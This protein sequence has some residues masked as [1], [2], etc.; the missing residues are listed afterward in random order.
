MLLKHAHTVKIKKNL[1]ILI[2][3]LFP[4]VVALSTYL[5]FFYKQEGKIGAANVTDSFNDT[6]HIDIVNSSDYLV[7]SGQVKTAGNSSYFGTGADGACTVSASTNINTGTCVSRANGDAVNFS[8]TTNVSAGSGSI[9]LSSSPTGLAVGDEILIINLQGTTSSNIGV[10]ETAYISQINGNTLT[11]E[12]NL[13]NGFDGT[14]QKIMVQ[15]I[16][17]YTSVTVNSGY[18][19]YPSA[20]NGAKGG[21]LMFRATGTVTVNGTIHANASGYR[22]GTNTSWNG[23]L[24]GETYT[25]YGGGIGGSNT[26]I[27]GKNGSTSGG[28]G[29]AGVEGTGAGTIGTGGVGGSGGGGGFASGIYGYLTKSGGGGGGGYGTGGAKGSA[30]GYDDAVNGTTGSSGNG[31]RGQASESA[32]SYGGGGGGGGTYGISN[33]TK[34]F[35]GSGG[36]AGGAAMAFTGGAGGVGGGIVVVA[37]KTVTVNSGG[38]IRSNGG[39]GGNSQV[40]GEWECAADRSPAGGGAGAG[41]S[42]FL[43]TDSASI[44]TSH[45][46]GPGGTGGLGNCNNGGAGGSGRIRIEYMT[47]L[48][49]TSSPASSTAQLPVYAP[50]MIL[51]STDLITEIYDVQIK[52]FVYNLSSKPSGT[53]ATVQFSKDGTNWYSSGGVLGASD[54]LAIGTDNS[55]DLSGLNWETQNFFY[56]VSFGTNG[57]TATPV[58]NDVTLGYDATPQAPT[59]GDPETLS[60]TSIRWKFTDNATNETGFK[61][62][63]AS[64]VLVKT[65]NTQNL[66]YI[67]ETNLSKNTQYTRKVAAFNALG[68]SDLTI[69][70]S[71]YTLADVPTISLGG[72]SAT[73]AGL[74]AGNTANLA[75]GSSGLFFD[76]IGEGCDEGINQWVQTNTD[77]ATGL[78]A[79]T[80]YTFKVRAR[81]GN[82]VETLNSSNIL[83][84]TL[85]NVP[86]LSI[87]N[88]TTSG[89][90]LTAGNTANLTAG[91]SGLYFDCTGTG[92]DEGIN[93]WTQSGSDIVSGLSENTQYTFQVKARNGD[94]VETAYSGSSNKYT[95]LDTPSILSSSVGTNQIEITAD[96][97][98]NKG[99]GST[100]LYFDCL[101]ENCDTGLNEWV[102]SSTGISTGLENNSVYEYRVMG[103]NAEGIETAYSDTATFYTLPAVPVLSVDSVNTT[104]ISLSASGINNLTEGSSGLYFDCTGIN[105]DEGINQ[106]IQNT[107]DIATNLSVNTQ[108]TFVSKGRSRTGIETANSNMVSA[109]TRANIPGVP[110]FV[111]KETN[112]VTIKISINGNPSNTQYLIQEINTGQYLN[113]STKLLTTTPSW[114]S[115]ASLGGTNGIEISGLNAG[116]IYVF[117]VKARNG[118]NIETE[119]GNTL[120]VTTS[121]FSPTMTAPEALS[122]TSIKWKFTDNDATETGF[123][124]VDT[125]NIDRVTCTGSNLSFCAETGLTPGTGY[126]RR[127]YA[128]NAT[129]QSLYSNLVSGYTFSNIPGLPVGRSTDSVSANIQINTNGNGSS[130]QYSI[131]ESQSGRFVDISSGNLSTT[132]A[133]A[134]Y[135]SWGGSLGMDVL[136]LNANESYQFRI[137]AKNGAGSV[138]EYSDASTV[139]TRANVPVNV[140]N[141]DI[142]STSIKVSFGTNRNP[143]WTEYAVQDENSGRFVNPVT[144][145]LVS[146]EVWG[147]YSIFGGIEG[148]TV[149]SLDVNKEY[150]F[151][152]KARNTEGVETAY[153]DPFSIMTLFFSPT[154]TAP[155]ALSTTSIKWKF[156]DNDATETGF[157][158]VDTSNIDRVTC[159]GSNLSFC[160]ETGLTPGTGYSRRV[161][162]YN[163]TSQSLYSNL[164]SGY[165]FSNIPGLPVGR[166]TDSV[167]ANIQIN[168]NGNGSSTQ[169]SI[170]ESQSGRF[171]DI[172]SGN[173]STTEAWAS[174]VS[175]GGSLGMDVLGLNANESYQFRIR[176][177]NGAGSVTEYSDA[178]TVVTR[179]NIPAN[180]EN[181][182]ISF[183]S[184][185]V[186]FGTNGNPSQTEYAIQDE[187]SGNFINPITRNLVS[188][189]VWGAYTIYGSEDGLT[190][191]GLNPEEEYNFRVKARNS[192]GVETAY[193]T[194]SGDTILGARILNIPS[195]L[196]A[197]LRSNEKILVTTEDGRQ[198]G[199]KNVRIKAEDYLIA[200]IPV[201]FTIDRDWIN[202]ILEINAV[203]YKSVIKLSEKE[204]LD[205]RFIMYVISGDT[206]AF[207]LCPEAK[208]LDDIRSGCKGEVL[209]EGNFPQEKE[210]EGSLVTVSKAKLNDIMYW[211]VDGLNGTGGEGYVAEEDKQE[212]TTIEKAVLG[213]LGTTLKEIV[214][215]ARGIIEDSTIGKLDEGELQTVATTTSVITVT[216]GA[217]LAT[218]GIPQLFYVISQALNGILNWLGFKRKKVH[219]GFVYDSY[220]KEPLSGVVV[221]IYDTKKNLVETFVTNENGAFEGNLEPGIYSIEV[222]SRG[223]FFPS[224]LVKGKV[225]LPIKNVYHGGEFILSEN[226]IVD[227]AIPV[228]SE[229]LDTKKKGETIV[230]SIFGNL[231]AILNVFLFVGGVGITLYMYG[232]YPSSTNLLLLLVYIPALYALISSF[233]NG[234]KKYGVVKDISGKP[235]EGI[236]VGIKE[237]EFG[238]LVS[239]R[240]TNS[241]GKYRII[242]PKGKYNIEIL[243]KDY[244]VENMKGGSEVNAK[245]EIVINKKIVVKHK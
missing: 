71:I 76:C 192:E 226:E 185:K 149:G 31:G 213:N 241:K 168:T 154:M 166:S 138:T 216:V 164:V 2:I 59:I 115:Y 238:Q 116:Q 135:V 147:T 95:L 141:T 140:E 210:V 112:S 232:K 151:R 125:S 205:G 4:I 13:T 161:Y 234:W 208:S 27:N 93:S 69:S 108:Y 228:D 169:Y 150:N 62:F 77:T 28:G 223:Y 92:C 222:K 100:A 23:G 65:V 5:I 170:Q 74:T 40:Y 195:G 45:V 172:S 49:G 68:N 82:S 231:F 197:V 91:S 38:Y 80:Q 198:F 103:R 73:T 61:L 47:S 16:P 101:S 20:W 132:E 157:K 183:N 162:A 215:K 239:K 50:S 29:A 145:N 107:G 230:T 167:S 55:I 199:T 126:S 24:A 124:I 136:G 26:S 34:L 153:R 110:I 187:N 148:L 85:T 42:V 177:K 156:T 9:T 18:S 233:S 96:S 160:A 196:K 63:D 53:T 236:Q 221:R 129:S 181:T 143:S 182:D 57:G 128:Y 111:S 174:Y 163:A 94:G 89:M 229:K 118:D 64:G 35:F 33:L 130:T 243:D 19:F 79:N 240:V 43:I 180:V 3:I 133:W 8:V 214:K 212:D 12:N 11:L 22:G 122:T 14:T 203:E 173:L 88:V 220:S 146:A 242:V 235:L 224:K 144:R 56:K 179:A 54:T 52:T 119:F 117:K 142:S 36:G 102:D 15:R 244:L 165:T 48:T 188:S 194:S 32:S 211:I 66:S 6:T 98:P 186:T 37:A 202:T 78:S 123:K 219:Y 60:T 90:T 21:V 121:L 193:G 46:T 97:I 191:G 7:E 51:K 106:W 99:A 152:V 41:G 67:D 83:T 176:A 1:R 218:G 109:Y 139:V 207:R 200:D 72:L 10:Y 227:L 58:L 206:N 158:I 209:F 113:A 114:D 87:S 204:G 81:N 30:P 225:D 155:E 159:T 134:S 70:K 84:Y 237:L 25:G 171:V 178:S 75:A 184:I 105:C 104:S 201:S 131:Q 17:Q 120:S 137:R 44:G 245:E 189:E 39:N 217:G 86:S 190:I 175:W 127:V